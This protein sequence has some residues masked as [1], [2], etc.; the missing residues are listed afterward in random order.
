MWGFN[1]SVISA[2]AC[3]NGNCLDHYGYDHCDLS[4]H[5][6]VCYTDLIQHSFC[7]DDGDLPPPPIK[8]QSR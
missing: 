7:P 5:L 8:C 6:Y 1:I 2:V 4:V 3:S